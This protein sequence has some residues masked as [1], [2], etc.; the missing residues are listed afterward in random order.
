MRP[1]Y[2]KNIWKVRHDMTP[3]SMN[4]AKRSRCQCSP[5]STVDGSELILSWEPDMDISVVAWY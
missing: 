2:L 3:M 1:D 5:F 4:H